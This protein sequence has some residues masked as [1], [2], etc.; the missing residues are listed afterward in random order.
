LTYSY[1]RNII[2]FVFFYKEREAV[3]MKKSR[4][5]KAIKEMARK[6]AIRVAE[7]RR[8]MKLAINAAIIRT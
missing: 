3:K 2:D 4:G 7:I 8:E 1:E 6:R 5:V